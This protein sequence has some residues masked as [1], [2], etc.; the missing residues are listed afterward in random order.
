METTN[1]NEWPL[2]QVLSSYGI[3]FAILCC[4][5]AV[6]VIVDVDLLHVTCWHASV[7][8]LVVT[9]ALACPA[10]VPCARRAVHA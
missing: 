9:A 1:S 3:C 5:H 2:L 8:L 6:Q 7:T 10:A 4:F